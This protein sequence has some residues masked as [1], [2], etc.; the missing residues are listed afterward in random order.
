M[1]SDGFGVVKHKSELRW[2]TLSGADRGNT[3]TPGASEPIIYPSS[4]THLK[5]SPAYMFWICL[6]QFRMSKRSSG[7]Q[8]NKY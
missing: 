2:Q 7:Q 5:F 3:I 6:K 8:Y 4:T 1:M